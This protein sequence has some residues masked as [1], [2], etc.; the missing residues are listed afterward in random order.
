MNNIN[1]SY[2]FRSYF[3]WRDPT[4]LS[5]QQNMQKLK[6]INFIHISDTMTILTYFFSYVEISYMARTTPTAKDDF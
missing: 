1:G 3:S 2:I 4:S 6:N 5:L